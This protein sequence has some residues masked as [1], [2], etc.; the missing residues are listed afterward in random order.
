M[1]FL[2]DKQWLDL[3]KDLDLDSEDVRSFAIHH[4]R[5]T[6]KLASAPILVAALKQFIEANNGVWPTDVS[7]LKAFLDQ[8]IEDEILQRYRILDKN[9]A[10]SGW[11]KEMVLIEKVA[12]NKWQE[13]QVAIGPT[14]YGFG[15]TPEPEPVR[16]AFPE[17]LKPALDAYQTQNPRK[18]PGD[19]NELKP[20]L[21]TQEQE[22]ALDK[23][24]KALEG[25]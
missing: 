21:T 13:T 10:Q 18:V 20:Y 19:F 4:V 14:N 9:E 8:P 6:A 15:P 5:T 25:R 11:L 7:Q 12:V 22:A 17:V 16:L 24:V 23:L 3:A 1:R 2:T